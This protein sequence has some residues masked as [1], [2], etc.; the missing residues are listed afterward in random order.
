MTLS[1]RHYS[2]LI[3]D[4]W[5]KDIIS[6]GYKDT[7][8]TE[9]IFWIHIQ[10]ADVRS[11]AG[12]HGGTRRRLCMRTHRDVRTKRCT[13]VREVC[14]H[15][16]AKFGGRSTRG[17]GGSAAG[18]PKRVL[19]AF[20][21]GGAAVPPSARRFSATRRATATK[22]CTRM[23]GVCGHVYAHSYVAVQCGGEDIAVFVIVHKIGWN[24]PKRRRHSD[25]PTRR[26]PTPR[27]TM[28]VHALEDT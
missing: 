3:G 4:F 21:A 6:R 2:A 13:R 26:H 27:C 10:T 16:R 23:H 24:G 9:D 12:C 17:C 5:V 1:I 28:L 20:E 15:V 22:L 8:D 11:L 19:S 14:R 7:E 25:A 18:V